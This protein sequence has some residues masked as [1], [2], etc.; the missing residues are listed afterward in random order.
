MKKVL[1][2][3]IMI[4]L[5]IGL[6]K[7]GFAVP[8]SITLD[9]AIDSGGEYTTGINLLFEAG[10]Y[11]FSVVSGGWNA[12]FIGSGQVSGCD[13]EGAN[14]TKGWLWSMDIYQ[15]STSTYFRLGNHTDRYDT[16]SKALSAHAGESLVLNQPTDGD[17][18]FFIKDGNP[19]DGKRLVG[20]NYGS[21]TFAVSP[22]PVVPEPISAILF[23]IGGATLGLRRFWNKRKSV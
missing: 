7:T 22:V 18:W 10:T 9:S 5:I 14:C 12:W 13:S 15:P 20:D 16:E 1:L 8:G 3:G 19:G 4:M 21:V 2:A 11:E 6:A 23:V 17:L